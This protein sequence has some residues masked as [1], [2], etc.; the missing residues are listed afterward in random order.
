MSPHP[1]RNGERLFFLLSHIVTKCKGIYTTEI[2]KEKYKNAVS[3]SHQK[4]TAFPPEVL[5][6]RILILR[7]RNGPS[8]QGC[9]PSLTTVEGLVTITAYLYNY[10][11]TTI[12]LI[13]SDPNK[14]LL[15][16]NQTTRKA[17]LSAASNHAPA[18]PVPASA[19]THCNKPSPY[20]PG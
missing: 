19:L 3:H 11:Y 6:W 16:I 18:S 4:K 5:G 13:L 2:F 1:V 8:H 7:T 20:L 9:S 15:K 14:T 10:I 17:L 12:K